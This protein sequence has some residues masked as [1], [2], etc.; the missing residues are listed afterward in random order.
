[1][2]IETV[3]WEKVSMK[4]HGKKSQRQ[5]YFRHLLEN[6]AA[7]E[8]AILPMRDEMAIRIYHNNA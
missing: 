8:E 6:P 7:T 4:T 1:M 3:N 2:V 5:R